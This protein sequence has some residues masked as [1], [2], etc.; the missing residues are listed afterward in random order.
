M[1]SRAALIG[2]LLVACGGVATGPARATAAP[3]TGSGE[4]AV[5]SSPTP[6][7]VTDSAYSRIAV[8]T[9]AGTKCTVG[10]HVGPPRYGDLPPVTVE[11]T[12]DASGSLTLTYAAPHLPGGPGRH[13]VSCGSG[14]A[15]AD[16]TIGREPIPAARFSARIR[17][18]AIDEQ[19]QLSGG[20]SARL[21][22]AL[23]PPRDLDA[24]VL[25]R[26]L[27]SEWS[28]ATRGL[29]A[30]DLVPTAPADMV[31]TVLPA[32]GTSVHVTDGDGSQAIF[33]YVSD[34]AGVL[35]S[36]NLVAVALHELGHIW[37]CQGADASSDGHWATPVADP[38]LQGVDRFGL[39][40]HPVQCLVF[41]PVESCPNRFSDR[42]L[43]TMGFDR[44]PAPPRN[45]CVDSKNSLL[46]QLAD[47]D[48]QLQRSQAAVQGATGTVDQIGAQLDA[49]KR[50]YPSLVLP[51]DVLATYNALIDQYN[52]ALATQRTLVA[53]YNGLVDQRNAVVAQLRALLC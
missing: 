28:A 49:I 3:A 50:Q 2:L 33:L 1:T 44:I 48:A 30:L 37:C 45:A 12:A 9:A 52:A 20:A 4:P 6:V 31:I 46:T 47:D 38:L 7:A 13:E 17:V 42:E 15:S 19:I 14:T 39:M 8:R 16:F 26:T 53:R 32:R 29:S 43:R 21:E 22:P 51:R 24:A 18:P 23:V 40:N 36:D 34:Q 10:I 11:G 25:K 27:V 5:T 41:G 35:T